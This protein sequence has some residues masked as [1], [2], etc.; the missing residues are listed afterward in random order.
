MVATR[1][2][3]ADELAALPEDS[4]Q[5]ELVRGELRRMPPP[6]WNHG[7]Y[8]ARIARPFFAYEDETGLVTVV[9]N[10]TGFRLAHAPDTVRGPDVAVVF[11]SQIPPDFDETYQAT[12]PAVAAEVAS[13]SEH[14]S[15]IEEKITDYRRAGVLLV[16]YFFPAIKT[17]WVDGAGR[18]RVILGETDLLD[19]SDVLPGMPPIPVAEIFR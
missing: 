9:T 13:P 4:Y 10:D 19:V 5:Y 6:G 3:T 14:E 17:V 11:N 15:E 8:C 12:S 16:L 7:R 1:L 18:E 2:M